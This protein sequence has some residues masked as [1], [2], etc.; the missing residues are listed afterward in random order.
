VATTFYPGE[1]L[2]AAKLQQLGANGTYTPALHGSVTNPT[3]GSGSQALGWWAQNGQC[4]DLWW[5]FIFGSSGVNPGSGWAASR[6]RL[7]APVD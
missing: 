2:S 1:T 7:S 3:L 5:Q 6:A 4:V